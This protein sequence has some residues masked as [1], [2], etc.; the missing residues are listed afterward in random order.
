MKLYYEEA[1]TTLF[2]TGEIEYFFVIPI[3]EENF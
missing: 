3:C 2:N 1:K